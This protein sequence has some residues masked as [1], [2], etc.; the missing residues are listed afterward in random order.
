MLPFLLLCLDLATA[1]KF[2][3]HGRSDRWDAPAVVQSRSHLLNRGSITTNGSDD[4]TNG[5][6]ISYYADLI[7]GG[8]NFSVL[9]DTGE[10]QYYSGVT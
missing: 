7:L 6:D 2:N 5:D 1:V 8:K 9:I 3:I 10:L 4:L